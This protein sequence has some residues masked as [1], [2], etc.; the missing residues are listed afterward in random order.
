MQRLGLMIDNLSRRELVAL[1]RR[2]GE[3]GY[4]ALWVPEAWGRDAF[5]LLTEAVVLTKRIHLGT[6]IVT[7]WARTPANTAQA[8]ASLGEVCEGRARLGLGISGPIVAEDWHGLKWEQP[9]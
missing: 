1:A 9:G 7:V 3:L 6:A 4:D 2:A 5:S 8:I